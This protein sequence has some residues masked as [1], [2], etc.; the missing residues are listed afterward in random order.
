VISQKCAKDNVSQRWTRSRST[1]FTDQNGYLH[2]SYEFHNVESNKCLKFHLEDEIRIVDCG[3]KT[4]NEL[5]YIDGVTIG[6][7]GEVKV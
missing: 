1:K 2:Q 7:T 6:E 5:L 4:S 3:A